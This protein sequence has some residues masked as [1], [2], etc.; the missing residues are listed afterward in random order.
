MGGSFDAAPGQDASDSDSSVSVDAARDSSAP[1]PDSSVPPP[2]NDTCDAPEPLGAGMT[3]G[4]L[5]GA[6]NDYSF[7][8]S[9]GSAL[10]GCVGA[11]GSD[12]VYEVEVPAGERVAIVASPT[13]SLDIVMNLVD[14]AGASCSSV[15]SCVGSID[16]RGSGTAES[17][18]YTNT[19]GSARTLTLI[20]EGYFSDDT[21]DFELDVE[22]GPP[23]PGD[24]CSTAT[25][26]GA[27]GLEAQVIH[28]YSN[29][30]SSSAGG[31]RYG[32][33]ADRVY[34][35]SVPNGER[36][37]VSAAP[38]ENWDATLSL[39]LASAECGGSSAACVA[40]VDN[41]ARGSSET[42]NWTNT[43]GSTQLVNV[44]VD[45]FSATTSTDSFR[46]DVTVGTPPAGDVCGS[47]TDLVGSVSAQSFSGFVSDYTSGTS[48][49][50]GSR[51]DRVYAIDVPADRRLVLTAT[52]SDAASTPSLSLATDGSC[53]ATGMT[54][55]A[56]QS[57]FSSATTTLT[58]NNRTGST[59]N[60]VAIAKQGTGAGTFGL[61]ASLGPVLP[62]EFC[63]VA[64]A[65]SIGD[66]VTAS[67][68][69]YTGDYG[70]GMNCSGTS[71][72]DRV[73]SVTIPAGVTFVATIENTDGAFDPSVSLVA[74]PASNCEVTPRVCIVGDDR[75]TAGEINTVRYMNTTGSAQSIFVVV[76]S[77]T[78]TSGT[79][80]G[81]FR[82]TTS[83]E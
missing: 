10:T 63:S 17:L 18:S 15:S 80:A 49:S 60:L 40:G 44:I 78:T 3:R 8:S 41:G 31:C 57:S 39:S 21:G 61:T 33:G 27:T 73:Y 36:L 2:D 35:V 59:Q 34:R 52:G 24:D 45:G 12:V 23:P 58:Y 64:E 20:V 42:V 83:M 75:G 5:R 13:S 1:G 48:C 46:L 72:L 38:S 55:L 74:G 67:T 43:T 68:I 71:G 29:D 66:T 77:Y 11:N 37:V 69:G 26:I 70:T 50:L 79:G 32:S 81:A 65:I 7:R 47:A 25:V 14:P 9:G 28:S 19:T 6:R 56:S 54:C 76:D 4:T 62:G 53:A 51:P 30:Y 82:L 22:I 16:A